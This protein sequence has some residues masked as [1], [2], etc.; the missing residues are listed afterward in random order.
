MAPLRSFHLSSAHP[1]HPVQPSAPVVDARLVLPEAALIASMNRLA[2]GERYASLRWTTT[3][4]RNHS[5][6]LTRRIA[7]PRDAAVARTTRRLLTPS[8]LDEATARKLSA[9]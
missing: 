4:S 5:R 1:G 7:S 3:A 9:G 8:S 2:T 6:S